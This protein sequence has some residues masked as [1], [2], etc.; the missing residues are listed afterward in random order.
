M[1]N[2]IR[3]LCEDCVQEMS[4]E[5]LFE[6]N[7]EK[8]R[9][10]WTKMMLDYVNK[11]SDRPIELHLNKDEIVN[12]LNGQFVYMWRNKKRITDFTIEAVGD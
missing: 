1:K 11:Q 12:K 6:L 9:I 7:S 8:N 5:I 2:R 3:R 10:K 4:N